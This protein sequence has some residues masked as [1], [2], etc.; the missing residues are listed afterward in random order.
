MYTACVVVANEAMRRLAESR[1]G[2]DDRHHLTLFLREGSHHDSRLQLRAYTAT[3][4]GGHITLPAGRSNDL[5]NKTLISKCFAIGGVHSKNIK[6]DSFVARGDSNFDF[7]GMDSAIASRLFDSA[8]PVT[9]CCASLPPDCEAHPAA[10]LRC[11]TYS[12]QQ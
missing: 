4:S 9:V 11:G 2:N 5:S 12:D 3:A 8:K 10:I 7:L 6:S 1:E